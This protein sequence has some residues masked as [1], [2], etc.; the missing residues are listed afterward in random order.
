MGGRVAE[1]QGDS[2]KPCS[3]LGDTLRVS[4]GKECHLAGT[5]YLLSL[6]CGTIWTNCKP[7]HLR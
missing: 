5:A 1:Q 6:M 4:V 2:L 7:G 3:V